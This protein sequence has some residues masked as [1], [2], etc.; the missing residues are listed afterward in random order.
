MYAKLFKSWGAH[1]GNYHNA[2]EA[3]T[4]YIVA[5]R[6]QIAFKALLSTEDE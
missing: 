3:V 4:N 6:F 1:C 2:A 5:E